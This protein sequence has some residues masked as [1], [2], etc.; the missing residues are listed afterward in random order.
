[1]GP[2]TA[3]AL[4]SLGSPLHGLRFFLVCRR[5]CRYDTQVG[6]VAAFRTTACCRWRKTTVCHLQVGGSACTRAPGASSLLP[7][8]TRSFL[9]PRDGRGRI[10]G[11]FADLACE[12]ADITQH[13]GVHLWSVVDEGDPRK[14]SAPWKPFGGRRLALVP[15]GRAKHAHELHGDGG[16]LSVHLQLAKRERAVLRACEQQIRRGI[17]RERCQQWSPTA[18]AG[19]SSTSTPT[20][21]SSQGQLLG[22]S[23][24]CLHVPQAELVR[25]QRSSKQDAPLGDGKHAGRRDGVGGQRAQPGA[26][27]GAKLVNLPVA[28]R[29]E[30][31]VV[32]RVSIHHTG[33]G[34]DGTCTTRRARRCRARHGRWRAQRGDVLLVTLLVRHVRKSEHCIFRGRGH[35]KHIR[36]PVCSAR[37]DVVRGKKVEAGDRRAIRQTCPSVPVVLAQC[38]SMEDGSLQILGATKRPQ[39][40]QTAGLKHLHSARKG[41]QQQ[42][43]AQTRVRRE[44]GAGD[45]R[46]REHS[47]HSIARLGV[48]IAHKL[49]IHDQN[50]RTSTLHRV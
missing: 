22:P 38:A 45:W 16:R 32:P 42:A 15:I 8:P 35:I 1:M 23:T 2:A 27:G 5:C 44:G 39:S 21:A 4:L 26:G 49:A 14:Q 20:R 9:L 36:C 7:I 18:A 30:Q 29:H 3:L 17:K 43:W 13:Q 6:L 33:D 10:G 28:E 48:I 12:A 19:A 24:Q 46:R 47:P 37:H 40:L 11:Q 41:A 34:T 50:S 31:K 25:V